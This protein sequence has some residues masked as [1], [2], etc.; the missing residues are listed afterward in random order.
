MNCI[1][2][3]CNTCANNEER[4]DKRTDEAEFFCYTCDKCKNWNGDYRNKNLWKSECQQYKISDHE[5]ERRRRKL[6]VVKPI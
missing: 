2:C 3:I 6:W 1:G 5:V 4:Y